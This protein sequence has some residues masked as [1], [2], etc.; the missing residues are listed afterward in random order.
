MKAVLEKVS[1]NHKHQMNINSQHSTKKSP[2][3]SLFSINNNISIQR[4]PTCP[5]GGGCPR[6]REEMQPKTERLSDSSGTPTINNII[7]NLGPGMPLDPATRAFFEPRFGHDFSKVRVHADAKAAEAAQ[8][9]NA[10]AFTM[11][12]NMV[13][14]DREYAPE[15]VAG[16]HLIAHE[17]IHV[18]QQESTGSPF[19]L[20]RQTTAE[21]EEEQPHWE[22]DIAASEKETMGRITAA[23][24]KLSGVYPYLPPGQKGNLWLMNFSGGFGAGFITGLSGWINPQNIYDLD[25]GIRNNQLKFQAGEFVGIIMGV[26]QDI[27]WN[28]EGLVDLLK[29]SVALS[30]MG[31]MY[32]EAREAYEFFKDPKGRLALYKSIATFLWEFQNYLQTNPSAL[33]LE[34]RELGFYVGDMAGQYSYSMVVKEKDYYNKGVAIGYIIG[35]IA[36]EIALLFIG[37][38]ELARGAGVVIRGMSKAGREAAVALKDTRFGKSVL[39]ILEKA[40]IGKIL[41]AAGKGEKAVESARAGEAIGRIGKEAGIAVEREAGEAAKATKEAVTLPAPS[42]AVPTVPRPATEPIEATKIEGPEAPPTS[43]GATF[44]KKLGYPDAEPGYHWAEVNGKLVYMRNP[45][46]PGA[47]RVYDPITQTFK[48]KPIKIPQIEQEAGRIQEKVFSEIT[49]WPKNTREHQTAFG[50]V[51]PDYLVKKDPNTGKWVTTYKP[52]DALFVADSKYYDETTV[53]LTEQIKGFIELASKTEK[54]TLFFMTN[55]SAKIHEKIFELAK[56]YNVAIR[57]I[58]QRVSL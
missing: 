11:G 48:D 4:K 36:T 50:S 40:P 45:G 1:E 10:R 18:I 41:R 21:R 17:L 25:E 49:G 27:Y 58:F 46:N 23:E 57:Q 28:L 39:S 33:L 54:K 3:L 26:G 9:V 55:K 37:F 32:F 56:D 2:S 34:G 29:L 42:E 53:R 44:A 20:Q 43:K 31:L 24:S 15:T 19:H 6:C 52:E 14:R 16:K 12:R 22:K 8:A 38:E 5:C 47:E 30:P 35:I 51:E 13:F 7:R